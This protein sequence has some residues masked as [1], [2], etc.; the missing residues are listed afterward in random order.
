MYKLLKEIY[1]KRKEM[2]WTDFQARICTKWFYM[3][4]KDMFIKQLNYDIREE[5]NKRMM[6]FEAKHMVR[7][8]NL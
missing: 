8:N 3:Q 5:F 6:E 1:K 4:H 7:I 2:W